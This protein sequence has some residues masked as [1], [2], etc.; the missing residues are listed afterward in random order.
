LTLKKLA[1]LSNKSF[2][3][4]CRNNVLTLKEITDRVLKHK[5]SNLNMQPAP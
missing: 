3:P 2:E 1:E 4:T 5:D